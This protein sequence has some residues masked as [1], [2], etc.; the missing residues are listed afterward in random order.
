MDIHI[1]ELQAEDI[2]QLLEYE[3]AAF[4]SPWSED[5]FKSLMNREHYTYLVALAEGRV[6]G[7]CGMISVC[8]EGDIDK[9]LVGE[10]FRGRGIATR[11]LE[12]LIALGEAGGIRDY[13]LEVRVSNASAIRV[14]EKLGFVSEG[15]RPRFYSKP[16]EDALIMWK[17]G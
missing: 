4:S 14:Y 3:R 16:T 15:I 10:E 5:S 7:I 11:M 9:V 13:T 12:E 17:R 6:A 2:P 8:G 1:R